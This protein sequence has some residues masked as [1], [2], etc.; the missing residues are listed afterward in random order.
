M[1]TLQA[2]EAPDPPPL[3]PSPPSSA[4]ASSKRGGRSLSTVQR[5]VVAVAAVPLI[6]ILATAAAGVLGF[7]SIDQMVEISLVL[8][9]EPGMAVFAAML[10]C[11]PV[12]WLVGRT[13]IPLR[14]VLGILFSGYA[15]SNFVMFVVE[16]DLAASVSAPFL[17][18]GSVA[19]AAS[20]PLLL[21][22]GRWAQRAMG[23][24]NWR[25]LHKLTYLIAVALI[26]HV[27]LV[28][29]FTF[30]GLFIVAALIA[31]VPSISDAIRSR[32]LRTD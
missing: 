27:G 24:R 17:V 8:G 16:R 9:E 32:G 31:R 4:R 2:V 28:G 18:A 13:Q 20:I 29:E 26:L 5:I 11:S 14:K 12:Q 25:T 6:G 21:T 1:T 10:W 22:S 7:I 30:F 19:M 3:T 23:I 15:V